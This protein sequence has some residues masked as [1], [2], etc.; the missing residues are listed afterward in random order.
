VRREEN[1]GENKLRTYR[2]AV[3]II[4]GGASGIGRALGEALAGHGAEVVLAD[5][6]A[7]LAEEVA[8]GIRA[9]GGKARAAELDVTDF[10]A[11][12]R[13]VRETAASR[14]RLDYLFNNAGIV[15]AGDVGDYQLEDWDR[16]LDVNLRGVVHGV[17]A[18]YALMRQQGFGHLVN[19]ASVAGLVPI[20]RLL[21]YTASKYAVVGLSTALRVEAAAAGVRVSVLC[22][23]AVETAIVGGG[24]FGKVLRPP[25]PEVQRRLWKEG[26]PI[27]AGQLAR[28]ALA[29][30]ARNRAIIVIPWWWRLAWWLHRLSPT[31]GLAL[32]RR[33]YLATRKRLDE[34]R[35]AL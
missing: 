33:H 20:P 17:Q 2:D 15:V 9:T 35:A 4:T 24:K 5:R 32:A 13:L 28:A 26:R 29:A 7:G 21:S 22:P 3:A 1:V 16:V 10:A 6:Q 31:L 14:G 23:G 8:A 12:D 19:T 30:V 34:G 25:P 18:A 11:V 27:T